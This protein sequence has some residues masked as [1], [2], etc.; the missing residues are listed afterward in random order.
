MWLSLGIAQYV[1]GVNYN[2]SG[3]WK[4]PY[5]LSL[6]SRCTCWMKCILGNQSHASNMTLCVSLSCEGEQGNCVYPVVSSAEQA[7]FPLYMPCWH[8]AIDVPRGWK[9]AAIPYQL[10]PRAYLRHALAAVWISHQKAEV[11]DH[12][13]PSLARDL[14][15]TW[16][17]GSMCDVRWPQPLFLRT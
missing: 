3:T 6:C 10:E 9:A 5:I 1:A 7:V 14:S 12:S 2:L 13:V 4:L 11:S 16:S 17:G 8:S 15:Y